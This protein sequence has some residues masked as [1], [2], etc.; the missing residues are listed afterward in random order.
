MISKSVNKIICLD[1]EMTCDSKKMKLSDRD[2]I[3]IGAVLYEKNKGVTS[4][5]NLYVRPIK[6]KKLTSF[7]QIL[8]QISQEAID[9]APEA[10][11]AIEEF[12]N[13]LSGIEQDVG[14]CSWGDIDK[15]MLKKLSDNLGIKVDILSRDYKDAQA[16]HMSK[17]KGVNY[18]RLSFEKA[19]SQIGVFE[20]A[21]AHSAIDDALN[22]AKL[23]RKLI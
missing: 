9:S 20:Q 19:L 23:A 12:N 13:W 18:G 22:L 6:T 2:I 8:T 5:F 16:E 7:C 3:E 21:Q 17:S 10:K 15:I 1:L 11:T 4:K 14:W